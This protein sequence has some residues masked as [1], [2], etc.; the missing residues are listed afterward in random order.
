M[1][2][3]KIIAFLSALM[4][5]VACSACSFLNFGNSSSNDSTNNSSIQE[6]SSTQNNSGNPND[7]DDPDDDPEDPDDPDDPNGG[8]EIPGTVGTLE[9]GAAV[10]HG[11]PCFFKDADGMKGWYRIAACQHG[12]YPK[13]Y[14]YV[15]YVEGKDVLSF[16]IKSDGVQH[17]IQKAFKLAY[18]NRIYSYDAEN[19][20]W[21]DEDG[22]QGQIA[23]KDENGEDVNFASLKYKAKWP[24]T[25]FYISGVKTKVE[26]VVD[27]ENC[28]TSTE[29]IFPAFHAL[30]KDI[31]WTGDSSQGEQTSQGNGK[32]VLLVSIDAMR[33]DAIAENAFVEELQ[34]KSKYT[35]NG[36]TISPSVTLPAHTS[37][38]YGVEPHVHGVVNNDCVKDSELGNGITETLT[39]AGRTSA[40]FYD[41]EKIGNVT[42]SGETQKT[43]IDGNPGTTDKEYY[44]ASTVSLTDAVIQHVTNTPTDFT[45]LYYCFVDEMG[46]KYNWMSEQYY[47]GID[48]VFSNLQRVL[49]VLSEEYVVIIT[50]D[51][52]GG[53]ANGANEHGSLHAND[54]T[55]P[56]FMY[57]QGIEAGTLTN[58]SIL[59]VAPTVVEVLGVDAESYWVGKSLLSNSSGSVDTEN[60]TFSFVP[61]YDNQW[62]DCGYEEETDSFYYQSLKTAKLYA[63]H[64]EG[65]NTLTFKM[66]GDWSR[67]GFAGVFKL[68]VNGVEYSYKQVA[69]VWGWYNGTTRATNIAMYD[70]NGNVVEISTLSKDATTGW[71]WVTFV[72]TGV[73]QTVEIITDNAKVPTTA[74]I[75]NYVTLYAKEFAWSTGDGTVVTPPAVEPEEPGDPVV[76]SPVEV[77]P[78]YGYGWLDGTKY[79]E[80][81][82]NGWVLQSLQTATASAQYVAGM[83]TLTFKMRGDWSRQGFAGVFKLKVNGVTY[84]YKKVGDIWG[85]YDGE[86]LATNIAMYDANG[87]VVEISTLSKDITGGTGWPWVTFVITG[88]SQT[89]EII[90]DNA[91]VPSGYE[92]ANY[93]TLYAKDF[94]WSAN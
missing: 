17:P 25:T 73:N 23:M 24:W 56:F 93:V 75:A 10:Y 71:P 29:S 40:I 5:T 82:E 28:A 42:K 2:I 76:P 19:N 53:G 48:Y 80:S 91:N 16:S 61:T 63:E 33:P 70:A 8:E 57:G 7:P 58:V 9:C 32:K 41:W 34:T 35:L 54:M 31:R 94:V 62:L 89:V 85:W 78:T 43:Y 92:T 49:N 18:N 50:S 30:I 64:V 69:G 39:T 77:D 65:M 26:I 46:H 55:T 84:S 88:V 59:D 47:S 21:I 68:K 51:H 36:T 27:F 52:G 44:E 1:K 79:E 67:Q 74:E 22:N 3:K 12:G 86:T 37:M 83:N 15:P 81:E 4:L 72:I 66:R 13:Q 87:N 6:N 45:F 90:T 60:E 11:N 14:V 38:F 20:V